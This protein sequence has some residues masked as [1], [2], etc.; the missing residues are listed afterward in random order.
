MQSLKDLNSLKNST[1]GGK[2][3][4]KLLPETVSWLGKKI[5]ICSCMI[6]DRGQ[7]TQS[8]ILGHK[9][10]TVWEC[11]ANASSLSDCTASNLRQQLTQ[12]HRVY[13]N[14]WSLPPVAF[15]INTFTQ[16]C[17]ES[18]KKRKKILSAGMEAT[19]SSRQLLNEHNTAQD[20]KKIKTI[21]NKSSS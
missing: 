11:C 14:K 13:K 16:K 3:T 12:K 4:L 2:K 1:K 7:T 18:Q 19:A 5:P 9:L 10:V 20:W 6:F 8:L 15:I 21:L 17:A